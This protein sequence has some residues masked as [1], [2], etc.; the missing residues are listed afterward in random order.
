MNYFIGGI[1][2]VILLHCPGIPRLTLYAYRSESCAA[3]RRVLV[4]HHHHHQSK[5]HVDN[6]AHSPTRINGGGALLLLLLLLLFPITSGQ[7]SS[8]C[9]LCHHWLLH[10]QPIVNKDGS[11]YS[12]SYY[13]VLFSSAP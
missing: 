1:K 8:V 12:L 10:A 9:V 11:R 13:P 2:Y 5:E 3:P 4:Y 6:Y 7:H